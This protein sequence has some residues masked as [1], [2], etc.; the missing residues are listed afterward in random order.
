MKLLVAVVND[1]DKVV[2]ILD[3][4]LEI[5]VRGA[6]I[7]ESSGMAHMIAD[8]VPFFTPFAEMGIENAGNSRTLF[9]L[10]RD[11]DKLDK[12]IQVIDDVLGGLHQPDSGLVF[13]LPVERC[14]GMPEPGADDQ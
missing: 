2:D 11:E 9:S 12:A 6:T 1:P 13:V 10:M 5:D 14:L 3:G 8:H 4:F 7:L